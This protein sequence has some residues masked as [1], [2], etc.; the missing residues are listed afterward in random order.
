MPVFHFTFQGVML[1]TDVFPAV[2]FESHLWI[3]RGAMHGVKR[4]QNNYPIEDSNLQLVPGSGIFILCYN[5]HS[6]KVH[7]CICTKAHVR[8]CVLPYTLYGQGDQK[9]CACMCA[10]MC[11]CVCAC[12][13]ASMLGVLILTIHSY[14]AL[15][16][17]ALCTP[18]Q[19]IRC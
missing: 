18:S 14:L 12:V 6:L 19:H 7:M 3:L 5:F 4:V 9:K 15:V 10:C 16:S 8:V 11:A 2:N 17:S 13:C 1:C